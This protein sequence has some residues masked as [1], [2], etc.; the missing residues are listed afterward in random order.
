MFI[1]NSKDVVGYIL[2]SFDVKVGLVYI[3]FGVLFSIPICKSIFKKEGTIKY[4]LGKVMTI[5][6]FVLC[7]FQLLIQNYNPFIYFNF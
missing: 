6:L 3:P 4:L 1:F 7:V 2:K 5:V